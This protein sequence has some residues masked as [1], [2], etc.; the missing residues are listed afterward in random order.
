MGFGTDFKKAIGK[1]VAP[2]PQSL[3]PI[4]GFG[5][6]G[7]GGY[8]AGKYQNRTIIIYGFTGSKK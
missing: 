8:S 3:R 7:A 5:L 4:A 1:V 6:A 2:L